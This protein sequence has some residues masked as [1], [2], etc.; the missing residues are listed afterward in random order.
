MNMRVGKNINLNS[1]C[2]DVVWSHLE[3]NILA[4][5]ATNGAVVIWNLQLNKRMKM[6]SFYT[7]HKRT[8]NKV[9][10]HPNDGNLLISGS[11]DGR[12]NL[13]DLRVKD[14]A[15]S[16]FLSQSESV[17]DVQFSRFRDNTFASVQ[18]NGNVQ[19]W[20]LR[21]PDHY[22]SQ[23]TAHSGPVFSC[24]FHL[25]DQ[26]YL[27]TAGRDRTLKIWDIASSKPQLETCISAIASVA[28]IKWRPTQ[29]THIASSSLVVDFKISIWDF[30]RPFVP[31]ANIQEHKD[32]VT[33][34]IWRDA[35]ANILISV[36]K[37]GTVHQHQIAEVENH[38]LKANP[39]ALNLTP[40]NDLFLATSNYLIRDISPSN[41]INYLNA[42]KENGANQKESQFFLS[43]PRPARNAK[44]STFSLLSNRDHLSE[45]G[46]NYAA[47][48]PPAISSSL[49]SSP[50][51]AVQLVRRGMQIFQHNQ[52][53]SHQPTAQSQ[54]SVVNN[55]GQQLS[56]AQANFFKLF[57]SSAA[58]YKNKN[59]CKEIS[60]DWFVESALRYQLA[61]KSIGD[62]F[63]HNA[64][65]A[66][67]L[68]RQQVAQTW[69]ILKQLYVGSNISGQC[70]L[71]AAA[72][73]NQSQSSSSVN[74]SS[75]S[76]NNQNSVSNE[77]IGKPQSQ[78]M[79]DKASDPKTRNYSGQPLPPS[80]RHASGS[81]LTSSVIL[82]SKFAT[83][84]S[85]L[86]TYSGGQPNRPPLASSTSVPLTLTQSNK[87][88]TGGKN[89]SDADESDD[90]FIEPAQTTPLDKEFGR[91]HQDFFFGDGDVNDTHGLTSYDAAT[92]EMLTE[93]D[94]TAINP[95]EVQREAF[96]LK[97]EIQ[98]FTVPPDLDLINNDLNAITLAD[99]IETFED[100]LASTANERNARKLVKDNNVEKLLAVELEANPPFKFTDI[101]VRML[102]WYADQGDIQTTVS[103]LI[104]LGEKLKYAIDLAIQEHWFHSYIDLLSKF[105]LWS[106]INQV[107]NLSV[108]SA[109]N[110]LNQISTSIY[111]SCAG[112]NKPLANNK[113]GWFCERCKKVTSK[114]SFC[115]EVVKGIYVWCKTCSHGG[116]L[117]CQQFWFTKNKECPSGCNHLCE[118]N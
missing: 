13:F 75:N 102:S 12:M 109:I 112:C 91:E 1:S 79:L 31:F 50:S 5:G 84:R 2:N 98:D 44:S 113:S 70:S 111:T 38:W 3:P 47:T 15:I 96:Q 88:L 39:C 77:T 105:Q 55:N 28:R 68:D 53:I 11:Q 107:S 41:I 64:A 59:V 71:K 18:E 94:D 67:S 101:V 93:L 43:E 36:G 33:D 81:A 115:H 45:S 83:T 61:G 34:F 29:R 24:D 40:H 52:S 10:F 97:H 9:C 21:K 62:L 7:D 17:R 110:S 99:E 22:C 85:R 104:I 82:D 86:A 23:F 16:T 118:Y 37:D 69:R 76:N 89:D 92:N 116:H 65:V 49:T 57:T 103:A 74:N 90:Q 6:N 66:E 51:P 80:S 19:I 114:C 48:N 54:L 27:A 56:A 63:D 100:D 32:V 8:V 20:N 72:Q 25:E 95:S 78:S 73:F 46:S 106:V 30:S 14:K 42:G 108:L 87:S 117:A 60:L 4:S 26:R 58:F 35:N